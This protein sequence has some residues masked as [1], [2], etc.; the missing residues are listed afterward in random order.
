MKQLTG[1]KRLGSDIS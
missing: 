1:I